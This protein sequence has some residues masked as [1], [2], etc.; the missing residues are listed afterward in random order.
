[1]GY[2]LGVGAGLVISWLREPAVLWIGLVGVVAAYSYHGPPLRLS[3]R[4]LGELAVALCYGPLICAGTYLVQRG[5]VTAEVWWLSVPLGLLIA[6]F[7]WINEVPDAA[8]DRASGKY[9]LVVRTGRRRASLGFAALGA[10]AFGVLAALPARGLPPAVL[11]GGV[12]A[13]PYVVATVTLH[14]HWGRTARLVPAQGL[15]LASFVVYSLATGGALL[16]AG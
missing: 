9:T 7:L 5:E 11:A 10:V 1:M 8:A 4:G 2:A 16:L 14:R 13:V 3:Y 6:A 15:T 12:A